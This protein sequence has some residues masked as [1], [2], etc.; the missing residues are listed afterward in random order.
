MLQYAETTSCR[1]RFILNYFGED[2]DVAN[3][4]ACD[5]CLRALRRGVGDG[6]C[7]RRASES[8]TSCCIRS[9]DKAR[10]SAR[11]KTWSPCSFR[12][13]ATRRCWPRQFATPKRRLRRR[14][15]W[16][17][18]AAALLAALR[19]RPSPRPP[20]PPRR[21]RR[22]SI[23]AP[24]R[25]PPASPGAPAPPIAVPQTT[26]TPPPI[27]VQPASATV[28]IGNPVRLTVGSVYQPDCGRCAR[29]RG[30][31]RRR[32]ISPVATVTAVG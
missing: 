17:L 6:A 23:R 20:N 7:Y 5:N 15:A 10:S 12:T 32:S 30:R 29:S 19:N 22:S 2:F 4:G 1:R 8:P 21:R 3:C 31:R 18:P 24:R 11:R 26:P 16:W 9:S 27:T 25:P 28:P 14:I 13:S